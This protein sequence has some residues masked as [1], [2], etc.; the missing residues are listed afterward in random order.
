MTKKF[1]SIIICFALLMISVPN[2]IFAADVSSH[3]N[4]DMTNNSDKIIVGNP[5]EHI[6]ESID[7]EMLKMNSNG[8]KT[9][10]ELSK[11]DINQINY[12][13]VISTDK[14]KSRGHVN[15]LIEQESDLNT[16]IY[17]NKDG[18]KTVYLFNKPV[19]YID[20]TGNIKDKNTTLRT[21][22]NSSYSHAMIENS[23]EVYF[24]KNIFD[25]IM[26]EYN[27]STFKMIPVSSP[28]DESNIEGRKT[29]ETTI[30]YDDVFGKG[31]D[32][33]YTTLLT[34][35]KEDII[36][37]SPSDLTNFCFLIETNGLEA[38]IN[39]NGYWQLL[40]HGSPIFIFDKLI[41]KDSNGKTAYGEMNIANDLNGNYLMSLN[42]PVDFI[43]DE[44]IVYPIY[45]DPTTYI[46]E[47]A[48][49]YDNNGYSSSKEKIIDIGLYQSYND[50]LDANGS[51]IL[52]LG[53][54]NEG[55]SKIIYKFPDFYDSNHGSFLWLNQ[56]NIGSA[57]LNIEII[58]NSSVTIKANPMLSTYSS[59][60]YSTNPTHLYDDTLFNAY[61]SSNSSTTTVTS[62][63]IQQI[64]ITNI[65]KGWA[66]FNSGE[67][68]YA[69]NNPENGLLLSL[70]DASSHAQVASTEYD[71]YN[72][73]VY[74]ELD[75]SYTG[76]KYYIYNLSEYKFLHRNTSTTLSLDSYSSSNSNCWFFEYLGEEEFYIRSAYNSNYVLY[77][78]DS[79]VSLKVLPSSP[80]NNYKWDI[81]I[82]SGG[83]VIIKNIATNKILHING[84]S[85]NLI[86]KP[87]SGTASYD[88]CRSGIFKTAD[89]IELQDI[90]LSDDWIKTGTSKYLNIEA[91]PN[92]ASWKSD[93]YF[94]WTIS[95]TTKVG[96]TNNVGCFSG[97][98]SGKVT[99]TLTNKLT[100]FSKSFTISCGAIREGTYMLLNKGTGRYMDV[101]GPSKSSGAYIQQ[102]DY[103]TGKQAKWNIILLANGE[104]VIQS[105]YSN[106]YLR[107]E[108]GSASS[109]AGIIQ[110]EN[111]SWT[112]CR[113]KIE[114]TDSGAY[115]IR[116]MLVSSFAL[117]VPLDSN[118][119]GTNLVQLS[120]TNNTNYRDEWIFDNVGETHGI[121]SGDIYNIQAVHSNK[122]VS[123]KSSSNANYA[124]INQS[125]SAPGNQSQRWQLNY[126]GN[127]EYKIKDMNSGKLLSIASNSSST[128]AY[129]QLRQSDNTT[130][131]IFKI[132]EE[133]DGT[134]SF[135]SKSSNYLYAL[136]I[137]NASTAEEARI[138]QYTNSGSDNQKF[139]LIE[140]NKAIIIIPGFGG[141]ALQM[142]ITFPYYNN[143]S[144]KDIFSQNR[145]D[146]ITG[147]WPA[148][149]NDVS[150]LLDAA[151]K[152][153]CI[154][155]IDD[156]IAE[157]TSDVEYQSYYDGIESTVLMLSLL[158]DDN[159]ESHYDLIPKEFDYTESDD[160]PDKYGFNNTY[161][162]MFSE[163][164]TLIKTNSNYAYYDLTLFSY[165]WRMSCGNSAEQLD[166][167]IN[168]MGY[169]SVVLVSHS[170]GGLVA[171]GY[172]ARGSNQRSMVEQYISF[173]TPHWG[174]AI[175][176][177]ICLTGEI[178]IFFSSLEEGEASILDNV[179]HTL[180][181]DVVI[182]HVIA[183]FPSVYEA[184]P[185]E[186]YVNAT[187]GYLSYNE[188][189]LC[190]T[191]A[192]TKEVIAEHMKGYNSLLMNDAEAF[193][194]SI[195][196]DGNHVTSYTK[197]MLVYT[198]GCNTIQWLTYDPELLGIYFLYEYSWNN[199][200]DSIVPSISATM[201]YASG[202]TYQTSGSHM[203]M[204]NNNNN[205]LKNNINNIL[206]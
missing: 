39:E 66:K 109:G 102:W 150:D 60:Q 113:W 163:L 75:Y 98:S 18:S 190:T 90:M 53:T 167:Y 104:Y 85:L 105:V 65:V 133:I 58:S 17:Q 70:Q 40:S 108:G 74:L 82:A 152:V 185:T 164:Q 87:S 5:S 56:Y 144:N 159:G 202:A 151:G 140:S 129:A 11:I 181:T 37:N 57:I 157:F 120:Y 155:D 78:S 93:N 81:T 15:R 27:N 172:M 110:F 183:N 154:F 106:Y 94:T 54:Y 148:I 44:S 36:V 80:T 19:K 174:T 160:S 116:P 1:I 137:V 6:T 95:D 83:G 194:S 147:V 191:Y 188:G 146:K 176:P 31:I 84:S 142:D 9:L 200:G 178:E 187:G 126:I 196:I 3:D 112:S 121:T 114:D 198:N 38:S 153:E 88:L 180:I 13:Q 103:H 177:T 184:F 182:R 135:L 33:Q 47:T 168:Q 72:D 100:G 193:H 179:L 69:Y 43:N 26:F 49:V 171:S 64:D 158:C 130:G 170:M 14:A 195:Y 2:N 123:V 101:E 122:M 206:K 46:W 141:S 7:P 42:V 35:V 12:P 197:R 71:I 48:Y 45:I 119:N 169:D 55:K 73:N 156:F 22:E 199:Y 20:A 127:G 92:N 118:S 8:E 143:F 203:R 32:I 51:T 136:T 77:G 16:I 205:D 10:S 23:V 131:Q 173:G 128:N 125:T 76:G 89:Y 161:H 28:Y 99:L 25:G 29:T 124:Q 175:A 189:E 186:N 107:V 201:N 67:S 192:E 204:I 62:S 24:P 138:Y 68:T 96:F 132:Q 97:I 145:L 166:N 30:V 59:Q 139:N 50:Y 4:V 41:I 149:K 111:Y 79:S 86:T 91:I 52:D 34:G 61:S 63:G 21:C 134:Y 162:D 115:K 165:D 117:S